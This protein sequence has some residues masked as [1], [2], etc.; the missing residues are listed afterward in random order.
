M[1]AMNRMSVYSGNKAVNSAN[2]YYSNS[3]NRQ[4]GNTFHLNRHVTLL[5]ED[6]IQFS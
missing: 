4:K 3:Y 6:E 2:K 1:S 5:S